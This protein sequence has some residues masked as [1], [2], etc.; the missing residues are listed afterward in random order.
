VGCDDPVDV[1]LG[2]LVPRTEEVV[3]EA[4]EDA[5]I[6]SRLFERRSR[7]GVAGVVVELRRG[8]AAPPVNLDTLA[9]GAN[10]PYFCVQSKYLFPATDPSFFP[11]G[12]S[13]STP[14]QSPSAN[15][16][17]PLYR[18]TP[19]LTP[20]VL[21]ITTLSPI[22][23]SPE[24]GDDEDV[25]LMT[26]EVIGEEALAT[27]VGADEGVTFRAAG[28]EGTELTLLLRPVVGPEVTLDVGVPFVFGESEPAVL[29]F[30]AMASIS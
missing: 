5:P 3:E 18:R 26:E 22:F 23:S 7:E 20:V 2:L 1:R 8:V 21:L 12:S 10:R 13:S 4:T 16:V 17:T 29:D 6:D 15:S 28:V 27:G 19:N 14:A 9:I 25:F 11:L 30:E 24:I